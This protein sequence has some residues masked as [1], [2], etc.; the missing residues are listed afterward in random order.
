MPLFR[1]RAKVIEAR[2]FTTNNEDG[3]PTMDALV[4]WVNQGRPICGAW[5]NGTDI[6]LV[7][8]PFSSAAVVIVGDWLTYQEDFFRAM[9]DQEFNQKY[10]AVADG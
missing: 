10:E 4:N 2:Q 7:A 8:T 6:F 3:S 1:E 9:S 5:H